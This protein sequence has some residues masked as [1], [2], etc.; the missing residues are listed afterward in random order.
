[1]SQSNRLGLLGRKVG[2]MRLFTDDGAAVP[3]TVVDVSN[4]RVTQVK[5]QDNDGYVALQV[6]FGSRRASRV[7]KPQAG[8]LAKAGVEAG[9]I[10]QEFRVDDDVAGKYAAGA[11][12][13]V[14]EV[15]A[16]GQ[17]VDVQG[18][19]IGKGFA[20]TIKRHNFAGQRNSH[21]NSL[22][23]RV[24]GSISMA[25]D[26]GRV[27]PGKKMSGHMGDETVTTQNLDVIRIDEA[28]QLLLIK[29]AVP[30]SRGG[31]VTVRPAVKAKAAKEEAK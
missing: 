20:G 29:G 26:P 23:H 14:T 18:T 12:V 11:A 24:P 4:N 15:F 16:V 22:S 13:P 5:T 1:M 30:G 9:E 6:T 8:H 7:T 10:T 17:K 31:F 19:S 27:F 21:G 28:R 2:M 25:Q 3:V